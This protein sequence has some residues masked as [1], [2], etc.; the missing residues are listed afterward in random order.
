MSFSPKIEALDNQ[1]KSAEDNLKNLLLY[2]GED[3]TFPEK[4]FK[5]LHSFGQRLKKTKGE[6][7]VI[8][9][10]FE[11]NNTSQLSGLIKEGRSLL[12][13]VPGQQPFSLRKTVRNAGNFEQTRLKL[14]Q[15]TVLQSKRTMLRRQPTCNESYTDIF[16]DIEITDH[17]AELMKEFGL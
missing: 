7:A 8:E 17:D 14:R 2:F 1:I 6:N 3:A 10:E 13:P 12:K 4:L 9:A 15:G 11:K 16:N 5:D